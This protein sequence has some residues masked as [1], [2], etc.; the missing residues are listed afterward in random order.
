MRIG[1]YFAPH[2]HRSELIAKAMATGVRSTGTAADFRSSMSYSGMR[3]YDAV[4]FYGLASGLDRLFRDYRDDPQRKAVYADLGYWGRRKRS[5]WD[6]YHK[7]AVNSRHP[8]AYFQSRKHDSKRFLEHHVQIRPWRESGRHILVAGMSAKAAAAEG[9]QPNEWERAT[10]NRLRQLTDREIVYRPKPN[11]HDAI[12]LEGARFDRDSD[13][14]NALTG[15]HALVSHH[16]NV[17]VDALLA[18]VPCIC[19][20]GVASLLSGHDL[21]QIENPPMPDGRE[22]WAAD[23]AWTQWNIDEMESGAAFRYLLDEGLI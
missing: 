9:L 1:V 11:W 19:P 13:L 17:A 22:Q 10:I 20:G 2:N 21:G 18:G 5:R 14:I 12:P 7:L 23:L 6:G 16:S 15:C 3:D 8:T 4:I